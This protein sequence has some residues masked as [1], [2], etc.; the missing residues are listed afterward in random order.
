MTSS[1]T[2]EENARHIL[3]IFADSGRR[4]GEGFLPQAFK[5]HLHNDFSAADLESGLQSGGEQGW[6]EK[7]SNGFILLTEAGFAEI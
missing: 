7:G 2:P 5:T 1:R 3:G 6:F 4:P